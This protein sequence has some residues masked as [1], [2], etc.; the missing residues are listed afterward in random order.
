MRDG[1]VIRKHEPIPQG[2]STIEQLLDYLRWY[3]YKTKQAKST[4]QYIFRRIIQDD[5]GLPDAAFGLGDH[6]LHPSKGINK[7][8]EAQPELILDDIQ[9]TLRKEVIRPI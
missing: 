5:T 9:S 8:R 1:G 6:I 4:G 7:G 2:G 3:R